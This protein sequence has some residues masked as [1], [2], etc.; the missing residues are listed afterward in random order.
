MSCISKEDGTLKAA[1]Q[2]SNKRIR[3]S[4]SPLPEKPKGA[5]SITPPASII[6]LLALRIM[7]VYGGKIKY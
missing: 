7:S 6:E 4:G 2:G 3:E 5:L 1:V